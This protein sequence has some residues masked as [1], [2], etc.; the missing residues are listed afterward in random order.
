[1]NRA[2]SLHPLPAAS[3]SLARWGGAS[4]PPSP[5]PRGVRAFAGTGGT[6]GVS[7]SPVYSGNFRRTSAHPRRWGRAPRSQSP[8][9]STRDT[10]ACEAAAAARRPG[11][12]YTPYIFL[13]GT[14]STSPAP[15]CR[16]ARSW[17]TAAAQYMRSSRPSSSTPRRRPHFRSG[18]TRPC[19]PGTCRPAPL[20]GWLLLLSLLLTSML[21]CL[22]LP[23][24]LFPRP[25]CLVCASWAAFRSSEG[26]RGL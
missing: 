24:C 12:C 8:P 26:A 9:P 25:F 18:P 4:V 20:G 5:K 19:T 23:R 22:C 7:C 1:M 14:R 17:G 13:H 6:S 10:P 2:S 16:K 3:A 21:E 11:S 15:C